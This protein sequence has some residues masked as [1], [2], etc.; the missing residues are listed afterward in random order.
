MDATGLH[1][2]SLSTASVDAREQNGRYIIRIHLPGRNVEKV[3]VALKGGNQLR[4][5]APGNDKSGV[6][7]QVLVFGD[8]AGDAEPEIVRRSGAER[9]TVSLAREPAAAVA[10]P[11]SRRTPPEPLPV[12]PDRWD[13]EI[14]ERMERMRREMDEMFHESVKDFGDVP[15]FKDLFDQPRFGSPVE[16]R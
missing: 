14:L 5:H 8:L 9:I 15:G 6:R 11:E 3:Q 12:P 10:A 13:R 16:L 7:E 4:I 1:G 2:H